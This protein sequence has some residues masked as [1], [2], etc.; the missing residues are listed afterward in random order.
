MNINK[1]NAIDFFLKKC[2]KFESNDIKKISKIHSGYTNF[3]YK[4]V[5]KNNEIFQIRFSKENDLVDRLNE[6]N[7]IDLVGFKKYFLYLDKSGNAIK[8][9]IPGEIL[10]PKNINEK[11]INLL[12]EKINLLHKTKYNNQ[13]L[14]HQYNDVIDNKKV[15]KKYLSMYEKCLNILNNQEW[16][17]S[18]NDL[19][20]QNMILSNH[21]LIFIDYE[22]ARINHP[23]WDIVNFVRE[24]KLSESLINMIISK[25]QIDHLTFNKMLYICLCFAQDWALSNKQTLKIIIYRFNNFLKLKKLYKFLEKFNA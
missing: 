6:K 9:W 16:V 1:K 24:T 25:L 7:V 17:L 20:L 15:S 14:K 5:T 12:L 23:L 4:L 2:P 8:Q 10:K 13:I 21:G 11:F 3:S 22:W 18:H 19:N